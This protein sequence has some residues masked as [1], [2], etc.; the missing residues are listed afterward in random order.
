VSEK[1]AKAFVEYPN[2]KQSEAE[3]RELQKTAT[4]AVFSEVDDLDEVAAIVE[5]ILGSLV[6]TTG[7]AG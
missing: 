5:K 6:R 7:G 3:L 4:F 1:I 2:W